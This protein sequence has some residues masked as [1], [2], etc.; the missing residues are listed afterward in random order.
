MSFADMTA[1]ATSSE[2]PFGDHLKALLFKLECH[3]GLLDALCQAIRKGTLPDEETYY[4]LRGAGLVT[5]DDS[6][7]RPANMLYERFF[8]EVG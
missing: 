8:S 6:R 7:I 1:H 3:P 4:R 5:R 2:G